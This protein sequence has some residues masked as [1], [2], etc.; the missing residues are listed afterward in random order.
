LWLAF[1]AFLW[2]P[3]S[4]TPV[5]PLTVDWAL[6]HRSL[7]MKMHYIILYFMPILDLMEPCFSLLLDDSSIWSWY[8]TTQKVLKSFRDWVEELNSVGRLRQNGQED[9]RS[10][11]EFKERTSMGKCVCSCHGIFYSKRQSNNRRA[12]QIYLGPSCVWHRSP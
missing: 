8:E 12:E 3:R 1:P 4:P 10:D 9:S 6:L 7:I 11:N 5:I 2:N